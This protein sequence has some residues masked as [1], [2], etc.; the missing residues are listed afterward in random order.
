MKF[1]GKIFFRFV[2][3]FLLCASACGPCSKNGQ[4]LLTDEIINISDSLS[5]KMGCI[6]ISSDLL[7]MNKRSAADQN[8][9]YKYIDATGDSLLSALGNS[10][11]GP[12]GARAIID[13]VYK[14]WN[15]GFDPRDTL[16]ET[17][18]PE[19]VYSHKKG[20]CLGV[21][22]I[23][24]MLAEKIKCP[25]HGVMLPGHFFCRFDDGAV[26][27]NIEPNKS[28]FEHSDDYYRQRYVSGHVPRY[29]LK[30][31]DKK[32]ILGVLCFNAGNIWLRH[33]KY[34]RA[35][36]YFVESVRRV[37]GFVEAKGNLALA[38]GQ[39]GDLEESR[40]IFD[41]LFNAYPDLNGLAANYGMVLLALNDVGKA[42]EVL[43]KGRTYFP[44]DSSIL[45]CLAATYR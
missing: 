25:I 1:P 45:S 32:E 7:S 44:A 15:I 13:L 27:F 18:L 34:A 42:R 36:A 8:A 28:G 5:L 41:T 12:A 14:T 39:S 24:L 3:I 2:G 9:F 21:S 31:I 30:N 6:R 38:Y 10:A 43:T 33:K 26:R 11:A 16:V 40:L 35:R 37:P 19:L 29:G 23:I 22:L 4:T 17:L 20:A